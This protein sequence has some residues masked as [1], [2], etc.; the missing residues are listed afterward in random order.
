MKK[1]FND[2]THDSSQVY[3]DQ[4]HFTRVDYLV[5]DEVRC[6]GGTKPRVSLDLKH[7]L[8]LES[9]IED[10]QQL[11]P[12]IVGRGSLRRGSRR[13]RRFRLQTNF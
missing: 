11:D 4:K 5:L 7:V 8:L 3:S 2:S 12:V 9:Q 6:D 13:F 10:E 1:I